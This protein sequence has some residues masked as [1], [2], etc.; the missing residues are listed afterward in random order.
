MESESCSEKRFFDEH[1]QVHDLLQKLLSTRPLTPHDDMDQDFLA[2]H[3]TITR[4]VR[5]FRD[6]INQFQ[7]QYNTIQKVQIN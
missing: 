4:I 5:F 3:S 1:Q 7:S 6:D 2:V